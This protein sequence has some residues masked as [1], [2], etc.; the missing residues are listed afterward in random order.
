[1]VKDGKVVAV[2]V[3]DRGQGIVSA[4]EAGGMSAL[5]VKFQP[6]NGDY[7]PVAQAEAYAVLDR[8]V[9]A[10][11]MTAK[12]TRYTSCVCVC[13]CVCVCMCL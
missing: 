2:N 10:I 7:Y 13:L 12:G 9:G 5:R 1:M 3:K 11:K 4:V 8:E 6:E